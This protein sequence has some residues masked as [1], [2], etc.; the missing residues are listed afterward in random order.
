MTATRTL[1]A[2]I[3]FAGI[4]STLSAADTVRYESSA[5]T[6]EM[7]IE[8]H[9]TGHSWHVKG[10]IISGSFE[11]EPAWQKD[12]SLKS[13]TCL[14]EGKTPPKCEL[15]I[16]IN[17]LKSQVVAGASIMDDR[18]KK[19]MKA[20]EFPRILYKLTEMKLA[21]EVPASGSPVTFATKG[22]LAIAGKTNEVSFPIKLDRLE[23]G[24]LLFTGTYKMKMTDF[25]VT[26]PEFTIMGIGSKTA[27]DITLNWKWTVG[28]KAPAPAQ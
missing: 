26:P 13:V 15:N 2:G 6:N 27:D 8:G 4:T 23:G 5:K 22:Q 7:V 19:E 16:P 21:G 24:K 25:G 9:A 11:V 3:L 10:I 1:L 12:L 14:G 18:M 28:V 20:S 17:S